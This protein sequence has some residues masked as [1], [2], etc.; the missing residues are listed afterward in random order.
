MMQEL[1]RNVNYL[2][3]VGFIICHKSSRSVTYEESWTHFENMLEYTLSSLWIMVF[4]VITQYSLADMDKYSERLCCF[5][6]HDISMQQVHPKH[7][8]LFT[9]LHDITS[10]N[11]VTWILTAVRT[12]NYLFIL[13]TLPMHPNKLHREAR[14]MKL[15]NCA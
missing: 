10:K 2:F 9:N 3:A 5:H 4:W 8:Y 11:T 13:V 14:D 7:Q 6:R 15:Y 1:F 12:S